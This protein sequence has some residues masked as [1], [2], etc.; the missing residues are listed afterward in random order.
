MENLG[1]C[2]LGHRFV[3]DTMCFC[4][5][6]E[7]WFIENRVVETQNKFISPRWY[8]LRSKISQSF[9]AIQ[10][11]VEDSHGQQERSVIIDKFCVLTS[12]CT[13]DNIFWISVV[14]HPSLIDLV[15]QPPSFCRSSLQHELNVSI[16]Q[17][18]SEKGPKS[19]TS[20]TVDFDNECELDSITF[21]Y[22]NRIILCSQRYQNTCQI[23]FTEVVLW[24]ALVDHQAFHGQDFPHPLYLLELDACA[25]DILRCRLH[26]FL[27]HVCQFLSLV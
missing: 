17:A 27:F 16:T 15:Y 5:F 12:S 21:W 2:S 4:A 23:S 1:E 3:T 7:D 18:I 14:L 22:E 19:C 11:F 25:Q 20:P 9:V 10:S 24:L 13:K 6:A 8:L 26:F